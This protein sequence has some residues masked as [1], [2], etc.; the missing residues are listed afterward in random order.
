[1]LA[2]LNLV[3]SSPDRRGDLSIQTG[4]DGGHNW[5]MVLQMRSRPSS[6]AMFHVALGTD[7]CYPDRE[8]IAT[9]TQ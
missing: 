6:I 3:S 7:M 1:M 8:L 9:S 4:V 2:H 5:G